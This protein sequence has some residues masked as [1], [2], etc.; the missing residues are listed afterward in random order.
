MPVAVYRSYFDGGRRAGQVRRL[1][2]LREDGPFA[3]QQALCS[4]AMWAARNSRA[5]VIDPMPATPPPGLSWCACCVGRLAERLG[6]LAAVA[7]SLASKGTQ[8]AQHP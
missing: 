5:M 1:H 3:Y 8:R 7:S 4:Q 6:L 2:I